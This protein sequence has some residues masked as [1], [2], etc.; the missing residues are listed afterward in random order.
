M[1]LG[2]INVTE[3]QVFCFLIQLSAYFFGPLWWTTKV[4]LLGYSLEYKDFVVLF[5]IFSTIV[6][7]FNNFKSVA[8][9][10]STDKLNPITVFSKLTPIIL[11]VVCPTVWFLNTNGKVLSNDPQ[12]FL[13]S[14]G[15]LFATLVGKIVYFRVCGKKEIEAF[16]YL[17][18]PLVVGAIGSFSF[19]R[20][21]VSK[22]PILNDD[23]LYV[24]IY[25]M[26]TLFAYLHLAH[27]VIEDLTDYLKNQMLQNST[28]R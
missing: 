5:G 28:H 17:I 27:S 16:P 1:E 13:L 19:A 4:S 11:T 20:P 7:L 22:I 15:F 8:H 21:F 24:R 6:T 26:I 3:I 2:V 9:H 18:I 23:L 10:I 25:C 14:I 12:F